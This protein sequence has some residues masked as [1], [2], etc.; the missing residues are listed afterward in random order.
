MTPEQTIE[1]MKE[2]NKPWIAYKVLAAGAIHPREGFKYA[3]KNGADFVN[4]GMYDFQVLEDA[5]I[6][7]KLLSTKEIKNRTRPWK[8]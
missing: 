4:V 8:A 6:A 3:F 2:V 7:K 5:A 1:F